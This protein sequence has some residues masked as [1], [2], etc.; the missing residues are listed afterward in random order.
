MFCWLRRWDWTILIQSI[1]I[2]A[3][4]PHLYLEYTLHNIMSTCL[5][6]LEHITHPIDLHCH[7][8]QLCYSC[9]KSHVQESIRSGTYQAFSSIKCPVCTDK[10]VMAEQIVPL[11]NP[12]DQELIQEAMLKVYLRQTKDIH[13]CPLSTCTY[14]AIQ[15]ESCLFSK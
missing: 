15:P 12:D 3:S 4:I 6:C 14:A 9:F 7:Q 10:A 1:V 8:N 13:R 2:L 5:I 11:L